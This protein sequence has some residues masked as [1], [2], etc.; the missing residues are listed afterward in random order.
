MLNFTLVHYI[1]SI[2]LMFLILLSDG[3]IGAD[4]EET[5]KE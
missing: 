1:K 5:Q 4:Y 3:K 2:N